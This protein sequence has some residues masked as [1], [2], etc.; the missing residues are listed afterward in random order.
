MNKLKAIIR[1]L[2]FPNIAVIIINTLV[3]TVLLIYTFVRGREYSAI[4]YVSYLLSAYALTIVCVRIPSIIRRIKRFVHKTETAHKYFTDDTFRIGVS[5]YT[6]LTVNSI[7]A[8]VKLFTGLFYKSLW[9][10][11]LAVYYIMLTF[12]RFLLL[13]QING[14]NIGNDYI[15]ELKVYRICGVILLFMNVALS[16]IVTMVVVKNK[17]F[18]YFGILIYVMAAYTFYTT[19]NSIVNVVKYHKL[20]SPVLSAAKTTNLVAA[21]V[22]MLSLET[23][24]VAQ[25]GDDEIFRRNITAVTGAVVCFVVLGTAIYMIVSSTV[26]IHKLPKQQIK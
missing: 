7:Y 25:F 18:K 23:A 20:N 16:I 13:R 3:S 6:S 22:S 17:G 4:G 24:M 19:I 1:K 10:I 12:M 8:A 14:N 26:K 9:F 15:A 5:L 11:T 21:L 2:L